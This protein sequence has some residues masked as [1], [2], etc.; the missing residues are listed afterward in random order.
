M[1]VQLRPPRFEDAAALAAVFGE[2]GRT[3]GADLESVVE[4]ESWFTSPGVDLD[5]DARV[6]LIDGEIVGYGDASDA[7]NDG[8]AIYLDLRVHPAHVG[9]AESALF[10][11]LEDRAAELA[12]P[13]AVLRIWS[14]D[15]IESLRQLIERRGYEFDSYSFRMGIEL[16]GELPEP[17]W[18]EDISLRPFDRESDTRLVYGANQEAFEDE[19][20]HVRDPY[21]EWVH[22]AFHEPFDPD[23]W[24]LAFDGGELAGISLCRPYRGDDHDRG[25]VQVLGVRRPWRRRGL[26]LALLRHSL[27]ELQARGKRRA[28]LGVHADNLAGVKLY[29][30]AGM[31]QERTSL[32]YR[33]KA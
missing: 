27:R 13:G 26:G 33:K 2:F 25:W 12:K 17:E 24:F 14:P 29:E 19:P 31:K 32:W 22:W 7:A 20:G 5:R 3:F 10:D 23:L 11:F 21:D 18:P 6:A 28:G 4:L 16:D 30:R 9:K 15:R 1:S 8:M